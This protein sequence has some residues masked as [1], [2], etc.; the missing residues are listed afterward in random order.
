[1]PAVVIS[2][3]W[4]SIPH[5]MEFSNS[6]GSTSSTGKATSKVTIARKKASATTT[7][8]GSR[9][10][11]GHLTLHFSCLACSSY[12]RFP[13]S[14]LLPFPL[15]TSLV[16]ALLPL[17]FFALPSKSF[18]FLPVSPFIFRLLP[19]DPLL[20]GLDSLSFG[21]L[22]SSDSFPLSLNFSLFVFYSNILLNRTLVL[23]MASL[24]YRFKICK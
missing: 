22:F 15:N 8:T 9:V 19:S 14:Q 17:V 12:L 23:L 1:M 18:S 3:D 13:T 20:L 16:F 2:S 21:F 6:I 7:V 24:K 5:E 11:H 10:S 4:F